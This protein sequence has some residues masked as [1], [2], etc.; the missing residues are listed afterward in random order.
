MSSSA[1]GIGMSRDNPE[2]RPS[3]ANNSKEPGCKPAGTPAT[4]LRMETRGGSAEHRC[5]HPVAWHASRTAGRP[6]DWRTTRTMRKRRLS[7]LKMRRLRTSLMT[8]ARLGLPK[9]RLSDFSWLLNLFCRELALLF[10]ARFHG[11]STIG[12]SE[13]VGRSFRSSIS[14]N[15]PARK[16]SFRRRFSARSLRSS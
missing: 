5:L 10:I 1:R 6:G 15:A 12:R 9:Y 3:E 4:W 13:D 16:S 7:R 11:V 8:L 2:A 14:G